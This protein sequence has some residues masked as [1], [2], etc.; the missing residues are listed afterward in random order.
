[1]SAAGGRVASPKSGP[2]T[3]GT[4]FSCATAEDYENCNVHGL[5][6]T[7]RCD[8]AQSKAQIY[9]YL[10]VVQLDDWI[11]RDGRIILCE[12]LIKSTLG[13]IKA[14]L[15]AAGYSE[16]VMQTET[17]AAILET[18]FPETEEKQKAKVREQFRTLLENLEQLN[19]CEES[20]PLDGRIV[21]IADRYSSERD[22]LIKEL[23][24]QKLNGYYFLETVTSE[25]KPTGYIVLLREVRHI[26]RELAYWIANGLS[27]SEYEA[28]YAQNKELFGRLSF[29]EEEVSMPMGLLQSPDIEHLMQVFSFLFSRIGLPDLDPKYVNEIWE[30]Q[31]S[32]ERGRK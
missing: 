12:R 11:H 26:P 27:K 17:P 22:T 2:L 25:N 20:P 21:Q 31:P 24:A 7:A 15:R 29:C 16:S 19:A 6:I 3:Q 30:R 8:I 28:A 32:V 10:P 14:V 4:I 18:L 5:I 9:N 23:A 1:M 13:K